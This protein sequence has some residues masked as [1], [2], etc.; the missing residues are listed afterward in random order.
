MACTT[1]LE[2]GENLGCVLINLVIY[3]LIVA[4]IVG[5]LTKIKNFKLF[6]VLIL[7]QKLELSTLVCTSPN[8]SYSLG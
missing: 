5:F 7:A 2:L 8:L 3:T 1:N 6:L 4:K